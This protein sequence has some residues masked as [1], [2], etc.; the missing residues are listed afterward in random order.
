[1]S[2]VREE[3]N[4]AQGL[5]SEAANATVGEE[6]QDLKRAKPW[7]RWLDATLGL[8]NH[9]YPVYRSVDLRDGESK[10]VKV[11]G[12]DIFLARRSGTVMAVEDRCRHRGVRFSDRPICYTDETITC[13]M[14]SWTYDLQSGKLVAVLN[15]HHCSHIGRIAIKTYAAREFGGLIFLFVGDIEP[16]DLRLDLQPGFCDENAA[17][18][19]APPVM[20]NANWRIA[21]ENGFDPGHHYIHNWSPWV[22]STR[23][24]M[25]FGW[26]SSRDALKRVTKYVDDEDGAKGFTR[27]GAETTMHQTAEIPL[28]DGG[29]VTVK[30]P[31][32]YDRSPEEVEAFLRSADVSETTVGLWLPCGLKVTAWPRRGVTHY[33]W[34]T[35]IDADHHLYVQCGVKNDVIADEE[36]E[37]WRESDGYFQWEVPVV[38]SFTKADIMGREAMQKFYGD[39]DGWHNERL[40]QPDLEITMWRTF[41]SKHARG[42]QTEEH[43]RGQ[44]ARPVASNGRVGG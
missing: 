20:V 19:V 28:R 22:L 8:R 10:A 42:V 30:T 14:H 6:T 17:H 40:Y 29:A 2:I 7:Q 11:L 4:I 15:D 38:E 12:E 5:A 33:E 18:Y 25:S 23:T 16:P 37:Q 35:P 26:V 32:V 41:A 13:W 3:T 21:C 24:P 39:E 9:W 31:G 1:M 27:V 43:T 34:Y 36:R 44:F